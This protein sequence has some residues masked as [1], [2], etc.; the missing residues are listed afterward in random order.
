MDVPIACEDKKGRAK[1]ET[2][3]K[4]CCRS[5]TGSCKGDR[6]LMAFTNATVIDLV[7]KRILENHSDARRTV[8]TSI[9]KSIQYAIASSVPG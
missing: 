2:K 3:L 4:D 8:G 9:F 7:T 1:K 6:K 5:L